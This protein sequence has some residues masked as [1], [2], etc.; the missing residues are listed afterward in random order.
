MPSNTCT[1]FLVNAKYS[2]Q[3]LLQQKCGYFNNEEKCAAILQ[4]CKETSFS[5][6]IKLDLLI[7]LSRER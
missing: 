6:I 5:S 3:Y 4:C 2:V 7:Y 1:Y